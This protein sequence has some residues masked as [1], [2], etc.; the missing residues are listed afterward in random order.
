MKKQNLIR[1]LLVIAILVSF[2]L[3]CSCWNLAF[4]DDDA[5]LLFDPLYVVSFNFDQLFS[6]DSKI[7]PLDFELALLQVNSSV[8]Y[9]ELHEKS[10]P[11]V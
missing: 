6:A 5:N 8:L 7:I 4:A 10:P 2:G 11:N 9:L 1:F 3:A